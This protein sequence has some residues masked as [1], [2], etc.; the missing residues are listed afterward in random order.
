M[1]QY[2]DAPAV[3]AAIAQI[4]E[5]RLG[6]AVLQGDEVVYTAMTPGIRS[7]LELHDRQPELLRG[8]VVVDRIIGRAAAMIFADGGAAAIYGSVMNR[9]AQQA[10]LAQGI[11]VRAGTTVDAIVNRR[12]DG[13]CPMEQ[14]ILGITDPE[15]G[16]SRL[17]ATV[18]RLMEENQP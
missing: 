13:I 4:E 2:F 6:L 18:K 12:G 11:A 17:R 9:A 14:A 8:A 5:N 1:K 10:L 7:A 3:C 16:L 15:A